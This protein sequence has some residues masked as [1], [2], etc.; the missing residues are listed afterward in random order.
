[1]NIKQNILEQVCSKSA[2]TQ[3]IDKLVDSSTKTEFIDCYFQYIDFCLAKKTPS[4]R[5]IQTHFENE[6]LTENGVYANATGSV[7]NLRRCAVIGKSDMVLD[8]TDYSVGRVYVANSSRAEIN[9][10]GNAYVV[11]DAIDTAEIRVN[12]SENAKVTVNA[13]SG[14]KTSGNAT[15]IHKKTDT[16]EL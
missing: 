6:I 11:V 1:M 8:Y 2:C 4:V 5:F 10:S 7:H 15:I 12:A 16:Y 14:T 9:A 13:Y 3:G